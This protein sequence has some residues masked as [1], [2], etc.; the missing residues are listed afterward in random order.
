MDSI[1]W[2]SETKSKTIHQRFP[3]LHEDETTNKQLRQIKH[4]N[5]YPLHGYSTCNDES[6]IIQHQK[7]KIKRIK[8]T[9]EI[10]KKN[11]LAETTSLK[12]CNEENL[13]PREKTE[14]WEKVPMK[15]SVAEV[16]TFTTA[17]RICVCNLT[18]KKEI[19]LLLS[20]RDIE[21][22]HRVITYGGRYCL[23]YFYEISILP[24]RYAFHTITIIPPNP[25]IPQNVLYSVLVVKTIYLKTCKHPLIF[26]DI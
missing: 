11:E 15:Q 25:W 13:L 1:E 21:T 17:N 16:F 5:C 10:K 2:E 14:K 19:S 22:R 3:F 26:A 4:P 8:R 18:K 23:F 12:K 6:L 24:P 9:P 20:S 7:R